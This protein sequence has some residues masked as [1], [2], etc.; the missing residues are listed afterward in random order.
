MIVEGLAVKVQ[1]G[2]GGQPFPLG[3]GHALSGGV[4]ALQAPHALLLQVDVPVFVMPQ[5]VFGVEVQACVSPV[6]QTDPEHALSGGV[7]ALQAPHAVFPHTLLLQVS[8]PLF[9]MPQE[10]GDEVQ[11]RSWPLVQ[12]P[13]PCDGAGRTV[14]VA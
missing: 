5:R 4:V 14:R 8:V 2:R 11:A 7:V 10:F 13:P 12:V 3:H 6:V 1:E 9:V